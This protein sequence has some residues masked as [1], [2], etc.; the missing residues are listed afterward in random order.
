MR[1]FFR[2]AKRVAKKAYNSKAGK[3][4]RKFTGDRY[5]RGYKQI[6][7]KGV[8][9]LVK[10]VRMLKNMVNA[11][12]KLVETSP[13]E[14]RI[15]QCNANTY[16]YAGFDITP[17]VSQGDTRS[18]RNGASIKLN[19][20]IIR[21]QIKQQAFTH[22]VVRVIAEVWLVKSQTISSATT[23]IPQLFVPDAI[24]GV[25]DFNSARN[26]DYFTDFKRIAVRNVYLP[27]DNYASM[28]N[29]FKDLQ[30]NLSTKHHIR[31]DGDTNT[32]LNGQMW[33]T[34]RADTGNTNDS[35]ASTLTKIVNQGVQTG[36]LANMFVRQYYY[37]N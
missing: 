21:M 25:I 27:A 31:Y 15:G 5:G 22:T 10:D 14:F 16:G 11:E 8:P 35:T 18:S 4:V 29:R 3:A 2:K 12:K 30:M 32:V 19:S 9:Q 1:K 36:V 24:S 13:S 28:T 6:L 23:I 33:I 20:T 17:I 37:D 26:P 34:F 7:S